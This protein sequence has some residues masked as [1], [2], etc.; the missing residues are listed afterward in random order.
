MDKE[1]LT[2]ETK[3]RSIN[4]TSKIKILNDIKE[5]CLKSLKDNKK[6][7]KKLKKTDDIIDVSNSI[8]SASSITL[9]IVGFTF[10]PCLIASGIV[11][12]ISFIM[13][14]AQSKYNYKSRY[15]QRNLTMNQYGDIVR[16]ITAVLSKNNM[17]S[18][19][20]QKYIEECNIRI[21]LIEDTQLI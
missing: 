18:K 15:T 20:Y 12:G 1:S 11:S 8:L 2:I 21:S 10:P 7:Y 16:E 14:S 6:K 4:I 3:Y 9:I 19:E 17:S 5:E 13:S